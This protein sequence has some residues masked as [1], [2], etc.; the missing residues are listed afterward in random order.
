[1][2]HGSIRDI[3]TDGE[4]IGLVP[5]LPRAVVLDARNAYGRATNKRAR[6]QTAELSDIKPAASTVTTD[7]VRKAEG[8]RV[9]E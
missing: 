6:R 9:Q 5:R 1:M 3:D 7:S 8:L 2:Y 4:A